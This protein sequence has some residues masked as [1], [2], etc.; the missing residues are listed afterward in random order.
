MYG[1]YSYAVKILKPGICGNIINILLRKLSP[2][3]F[4]WRFL[5]FTNKY[6]Q[7]PKTAHNHADKF[8]TGNS[9]YIGKSLATWTWKPS[10]WIRSQKHNKKEVYRE[11]EISKSYM[12]KD[13]KYKSQLIQ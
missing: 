1:V 6:G 7:W 4:S 9:I 10:V 12:K 13:C 11:N 3:N 2:I 5:K 8:N